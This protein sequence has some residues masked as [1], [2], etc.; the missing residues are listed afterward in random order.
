MALG[1]AFPSILVAARQ[2]ED[3]A[4]A[5]LYGELVGPL[6]RYLRTRGADEPDDLA[7]E[8]FLQVARGINKFTGDESAFRSWV[9]VIGHRRLIDERRQ[10]SRQVR[11]VPLDGDDAASSRVDN[12]VGGNTEVEAM[13]TLARTELIAVLNE[14]TAEQRDVLMLRLVAELPLE[15]TAAAMGKKV[16]AVKTLQF[17]AVKA[18][19]KKLVAEP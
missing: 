3:W 18:L 12:R 14:L 6:T 11:T 7:A 9:F 17:R 5:E 4:W 2:G 16:G 10:Q 13:A 8:T 15:A 19:Q 1:E